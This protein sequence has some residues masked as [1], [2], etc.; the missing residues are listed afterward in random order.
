[1]ADIW[2]LTE[3]KHHPVGL[4][5]FVPMWSA[6][7]LAFSQIFAPYIHLSSIPVMVILS[8]PVA[9]YLIHL[10]HEGM[11]CGGSL[12]WSFQVW[13][14]LAYSYS[15]KHKLGRQPPQCLRGIHWACYSG[16]LSVV[17]ITTPRGLSE[18]FPDQTGLLLKRESPSRKSRIISMLL[19]I[20]CLDMDWGGLRIEAILI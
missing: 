10:E 5:L 11:S 7:L 4:A 6:W 19:H 14:S 12:D 8:W 20:D 3:G 16:M 1:M 17:K 9:F 15:A 2:A 18:H 13:L